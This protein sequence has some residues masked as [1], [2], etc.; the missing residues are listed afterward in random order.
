MNSRQL[1]LFADKIGVGYRDIEDEE[2]RVRIRREADD[3]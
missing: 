2:L 3:G 1:R